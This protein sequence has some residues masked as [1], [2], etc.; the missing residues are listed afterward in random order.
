M[1]ISPDGK[2]TMNGGKSKFL[3]TLSM[4]ALS[5]QRGSSSAEQEYFSAKMMYMEKVQVQWWHE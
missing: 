2:L 3:W 5:C 1:V 4:N